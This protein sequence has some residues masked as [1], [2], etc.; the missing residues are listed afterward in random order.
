MKEE[1]RR[2]VDRKMSKLVSRHADKLIGM[3]GG[4]KLYNNNNKLLVPC[5]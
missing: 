5:V 2:Q 1:A 3:H 4:G